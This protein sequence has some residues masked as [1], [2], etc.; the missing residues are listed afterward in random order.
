MG[1]TRRRALATGSAALA[2]LLLSGIASGQSTDSADD[3]AL[4]TLGESVTA[5][6]LDLHREVVAEAP[7]DNAMVSPYSASIALAMTWAGAR[8][9]TASQMAE[10]LRYPYERDRLHRTYGVLDERIDP[11]ESRNSTPTPTEEGSDDGESFSLETANALWGQAGFPFSESYL[12]LLSEHYGA[13]LREA[14]FGESPEAA[15]E[16]I[17]AWVADQ[18]AGTIEDL[19]PPDAVGPSTRLVLTNAVYFSA[20]WLHTFGGR[21]ATEPEPFTS[22]DGTTSEV[23][24]MRHL[25]PVELPYA[26]VDGTE[27]VSLPY[28]GETVDMVVLLPP[29]GE[30]ESVEADLDVATLRSYFD[31]LEPRR[32]SVAMPRFEYDTKASLERALSA[33]GMERA[34]SA[35]A[36]FS[37]MVAPDADRALAISDVIQQTHVSV[38]EQGTEASAATSVVIW[39]S[40]NPDAFEMRVDR[41][42]LYA[43][44]HRATNTALFLGR[45]VSLEGD[46]VSEGPPA[47]GD[48]PAPTDPDD[49]GRYEDLN[50]NGEVDYDDVVTYFENMDES[51]MTDHVDAYDYNGNGDLDYADLV[52]LF[53]QV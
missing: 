22:I 23:P 31:A 25:N 19:L 42:F 35:D 28:E 49:D 33:M 32:G 24:T 3:E 51:S 4:R 17:N 37:G 34:F 7:E 10:A 43:I 44:R 39:E 1:L 40:A 29:E 21:E 48:G 9:E 41:P 38:D 50:G 30:F 20:S 27:V 15:R 11:P 53:G 8:S 18:T 52:D 12:D 6:G 14:D 16:R 26:E 2:G 47:V 13:G 36:D 45:V 46:G 5:F